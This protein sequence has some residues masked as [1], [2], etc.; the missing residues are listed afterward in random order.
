MTI[1][2]LA[3]TT[4]TLRVLAHPARLRLLAM[5]RS[6]GLCVCQAAA[7]L[8]SPVSTVSEHLGELKRAG[9]LAER[10]QG[11]WVTY[12]LDVAAEA[13]DLLG[14]L[15]ELIA[16]DALIRRDAGVVKRVRRVP[17]IDLCDADLDLRRFGIEPAS[18][19]GRRT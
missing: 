14:F 12:S 19:E 13:S 18:L 6:G 15:L 16:T 7:V 11:R 8:G 4:A 10:R 3:Q 9:L 5:L 17:P 1:G 2:P